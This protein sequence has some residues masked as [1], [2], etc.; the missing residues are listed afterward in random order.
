MEAG[1]G[2]SVHHLLAVIGRIAMKS[3]FARLLT[4]AMLPLAF[5][6]LSAVGSGADSITYSGTFTYPVFTSP[7]L[8]VSGTR[9]DAFSQPRRTVQIPPFDLAWGELDEITL[10]YVSAAA[11]AFAANF[12]GDDPANT[13]PSGVNNNIKAE[14]TIV[15]PGVNPPT[16]QVPFLNQ[17]G[18]F[19][20]HPPVY[21][22]DWIYP[23]ATAGPT[24]VTVP[25]S[26]FSS[27]TGAG[28]VPMVIDLTYRNEA[29]ISNGPMIYQIQAVA[30]ITPSLTY[31][32][33]PPR[34][35]SGT[36]TF[37]GIS[38]DAPSQPVTL[39][40][41]PRNGKPSFNRVVTVSPQGI[42]SVNNVPGR[43]YDVLV[44]AEKFLATLQPIDLST[45][46][47]ADAAITMRSGD[48]NGDNA[49]DI[50]D[51]LAL[52]AHFN[53][54]APSS[55]YAEAV[56]FNGDGRNDISDL[57]LLIANYNQLGD[58]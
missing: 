42:F 27:Y 12:A 30:A 25:P 38:A 31:V 44:K 56:D 21:H 1:I 32:F 3:T 39:T 19:T 28:N 53:Q 45:G 6:A 24:S 58:S 10:N 48:A 50:T 23:T 7:V 40:F 41:R 13:L 55:D 57:L 54:N 43:Q 22:L 52:I 9:R 36:I 4:C 16:M 11:G 29:T 17:S 18:T 49:V 8:S 33:A 46:N 47:V 26:A 51:L 2:R 5:A 15:V 14:F 34:N 20:Q 37:Q 35:V